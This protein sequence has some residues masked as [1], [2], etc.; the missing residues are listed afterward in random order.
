MIKDSCSVISLGERIAEAEK[1]VDEEVVLIGAL[2]NDE[3][4]DLLEVTD[5]FAR[6]E[7]TREVRESRIRG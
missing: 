1:L 6:I 5:R 4:V 7:K 3:G 2:A